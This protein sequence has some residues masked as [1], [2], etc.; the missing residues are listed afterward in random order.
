MLSNLF[1]STFVIITWLSNAVAAGC[2]GGVTPPKAGLYRVDTRNS[3]TIKLANGFS[4]PGVGEEKEKALVCGTDKN[5]VVAIYRQYYPTT[6]FYLYYI[7]VSKD[8]IHDKWWQYNERAQRAGSIGYIEDMPQNLAAQVPMPWLSIKGH[9]TV[10]PGI[11]PCDWVE[12][13]EWKKHRY[14]GQ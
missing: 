9:Q 3:T 7:D 6:T 14:D 2:L 12:N 4:I 10:H 8:H 5:E 13:Q 1:I 11:D